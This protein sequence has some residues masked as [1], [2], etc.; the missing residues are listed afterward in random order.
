M[1]LR[2]G[3]EF[4][5][6]W[7][8]TADHAKVFPFANAFS[9]RQWQGSFLLQSD[10]GQVGEIPDAEWTWVPG[11]NDIAWGFRRPAGPQDYWA[12][13][14]TSSVWLPLAR[15]PN[16]V[17]FDCLVP[18]INPPGP[19]VDTPCNS[20][21][22]PSRLWAHKVDPLGLC[23]CAPSTIQL[24]FLSDFQGWVSDD[25]ATPC[26]PGG[27]TFGCAMACFVPPDLA[28]FRLAF[29]GGLVSIGSS[30]I[31]SQTDDPFVI[32]FDVNMVVEGGNPGCSGVIRW[33]VDGNP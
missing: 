4:E 19:P 22:V 23:P 16:G 33:R 13:G 28:G 25:L 30:T 31:V 5:V 15:F 6:E 27:M 20:V 17:P 8:F 12:S 21:P 7:F 1:R 3:E 10:T 24:D 9:S 11:L 32:T 14:P 29:N 18:P 26:H 2:T